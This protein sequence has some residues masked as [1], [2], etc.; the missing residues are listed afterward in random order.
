MLAI[1]SGEL[2][3]EQRLPSMRALATRLR[4]HLNSV[5][6]AY[7]SLEERNWIQLRRGS[8]AYVKSRIQS[9]ANASLVRSFIDSARAVGMSDA[10]IRQAVDE[11][12]S[13]RRVESVFVVEPEP[14]LRNIVMAEIAET[15]QLPIYGTDECAGNDRHALTLTVALAAR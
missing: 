13:T 3:A 10:D 8:G 14:E 9:S 1:I 2:R 6:A 5:R 4:V 7:L 12:L 15:I 11:A